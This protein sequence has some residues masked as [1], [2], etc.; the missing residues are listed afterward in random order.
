MQ[1][2]LIRFCDTDVEPGK[3]YRYRVRVFLEDP[4][5]P[6]TDPLNG[7]VNVT[8]RRR[9]LSLKVHRSPEQAAGG[10]GD[11]E[12]VLRRESV[13]RKRRSLSHFPR[14]RA[15]SQAKW[16]RPHGGRVARSSLV[17]QSESYGNLVPV[18]WNDQLAVDVSTETRG[19][20]GSVLNFSEEA[21]RRA[22]PGV[23]RDQAAEGL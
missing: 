10:R 12:V 22:R 14:R 1:Y 13:E 21:V 18:V 23:A 2:K 8:P 19:Y 4:N 9:S 3:V 20:R 15:S 5:N 6:N 7:V 11:Q 17:Q 16:S